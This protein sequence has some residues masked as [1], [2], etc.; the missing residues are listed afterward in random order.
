MVSNQCRFRHSSR[1]EPCLDEGVIGRS[2]RAGEIDA[3][4]V[5][6]RPQ[7]HHV[8]REFTVIV[9][10]QPIGGFAPSGKPIEDIDH[11][12]PAQAWPDLDRERLTRMDVDHRQCRNVWPLTSL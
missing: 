12:R 7:I 4:L 11:M 6:I 9:G 10:K 5:V 3:H 2:S 1:K 8:T